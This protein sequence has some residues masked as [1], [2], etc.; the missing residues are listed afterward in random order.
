MRIISADEN[1]LERVYKS[2]YIGLVQLIWG[3]PSTI[4]YLN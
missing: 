2:Y 1:V 4:Y 3:Y